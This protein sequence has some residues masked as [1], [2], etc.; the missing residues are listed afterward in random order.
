MK[1]AIDARF[2][3]KSTGGIGRYTR[4]LIKE[5]AN[6]DSNNEYTIF[7]TPSDEQEFDQEIDSKKHKNFHKF[8]LSITHFTLNEQTRFL[9]ILNK[10]NF[11]LVHFA[12]FNH[13]ILYR[14]KF[15]TTIHDLTILLFPAKGA[16][17][18]YF[19]RLAFEKVIKNAVYSSNK[20]ISISNSTKRDLENHLRVNPKK[21]EVVYEGIDENYQPIKSQSK[22]EK[23]KAKYNIDKPYIL[24]VS[25][26]RPHKGLPELIKAFE[27]LKEKYFLEHK[28]VLVGKS[29]NNFPEVIS[30]VDNCKYSQDIIRPG[31]VVE[32]DL[33]YFYAASDVFV[34]P[35]HYEGFGL[36][37]LEAMSSG[38]P[39]AASN[40]S[41]MPEVLGNAA[42]Y[43]DPYNPSDIAKQIFSIVSN[44]KFKQQLIKDGVKQAKKYSWHK[45][46]KETLAVYESVVK[47]K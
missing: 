17:R 5:L 25:Q 38:V 36:P 9:N 46:A 27:I 22:I 47:S 41:S 11:D 42:V 43:F 24:F 32:E 10:E 31:F 45:M 29:D 39:V 30:A 15:V 40:I 6:I 7:I 2:Y 23:F 21:I 8:V 1:I 12:N 19:R 3:R 35:S 34:F 14:K 20:I 18:S 28:L 33:P 44:N 16:Q 26:W 13:P 4:N 37:P